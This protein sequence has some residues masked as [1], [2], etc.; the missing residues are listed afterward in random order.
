MQGGQTSLSH[1]PDTMIGLLVTGEKRTQDTHSVW[2]SGSPMVYLHSPRVFHSLMVL[3][4]EPETIWWQK[5]QTCLWTGGKPSFQ[6]I[7]ASRRYHS[8]SYLS[9]VNGK[10]NRQ[11]ILGVADEAAGGDAGAEVPKAEGAIPGA[12]QGKLAIR[13]DDN[14]LNKVGVSTQSAEGLAVGG[15]SAA[16]LT[17]QLPLDDSLITA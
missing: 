10:G 17:C 5:R 12:G 11:D 8:H 3:S 9:I 15:I 6:G 7:P 16:P 14:I 13:G 1:P 2:P 4:R